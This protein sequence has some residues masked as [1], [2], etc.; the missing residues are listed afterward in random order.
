MDTKCVHGVEFN[1]ASVGLIDLCVQC[2]KIVRRAICKT[3][4]GTGKYQEVD[5]EASGRAASCGENRTE[6]R[7]AMCYEC[8]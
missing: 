3:C 7:T 6:Y 1:I 2:V 5:R 8:R 4:K